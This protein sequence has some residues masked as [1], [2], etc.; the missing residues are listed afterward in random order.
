M[1]K[2]K[3][4]VK[5]F[6]CSLILVIALIAPVTTGIGNKDLGTGQLRNQ[7]DDRSFI[8]QWNEDLLNS[9][10][11]AQDLSERDALSRSVWE[12]NSAQN[13]SEAVESRSIADE[14]AATLA[15]DSG[16]GYNKLT[17]MARNGYADLGT[18]VAGGH[19]VAAGDTQPVNAAQNPEWENYPGRGSSNDSS[20]DDNTYTA[21]PE[22]QNPVDNGQG[23]N[24]DNGGGGTVPDNPVVPAP[25]A[26]ILTAI[27]AAIARFLVQKK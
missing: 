15:E 27:G 25:A 4:Y 20:R 3:K 10:N 17:E 7:I 23:G 24:T 12:L 19:L 5:V 26:L 6:L 11:N 14:L 8:P 13:F 22:P 21:V 9:I 2:A 18:K 1:N 16:S